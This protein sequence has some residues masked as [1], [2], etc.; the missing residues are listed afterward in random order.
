MINVLFILDVENYECKL[1]S[2]ACVPKLGHKVEVINLHTGNREL[3][4]ITE[5]IHFNSTKR[6]YKATDPGELDR[7]YITVP[8]PGL[9]IKLE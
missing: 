2:L 3:L 8:D 1:E 7:P 5:I 9:K 6:L 4:T